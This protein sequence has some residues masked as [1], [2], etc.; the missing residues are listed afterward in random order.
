MANFTI[1]A[2]WATPVSTE[3]PFDRSLR[4]L[5]ALARLR[6]VARLRNRALR[7]ARAETLDPHLLDDIGVA[8][9]RRQGHDWISW[10]AWGQSG[11]R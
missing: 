6:R 5:R 10:L 2:S 9:P 8:V 11:S 7:L 1:E 4:R 3:R